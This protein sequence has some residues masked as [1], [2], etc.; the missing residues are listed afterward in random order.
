[1]ITIVFSSILFSENMGV[2]KAKV[3]K[4]IKYGF[5][6]TTFAEVDRNDA[7]TALKTWFDLLCEESGIDY[8]SEVYIYDS[9][10]LILEAIK[11][12]KIDFVIVSPME[13]LQ[14]K[15]KCSIIPVYFGLLDGKPDAVELLLVNADSKI[16][17]VN[18]LKGKTLL[19]ERYSNGRIPMI[20]LETILLKNML[21]ETGK[22]FHS[23]RQLEKVSQAV[24]PV[25]FRQA[26]ACIVRETAFETMVELNPQIG[27]KL[28]AIASSSPL[29]IG[30]ICY[31]EGFNENDLNIIT[32]S[33]LN[34]H[35]SVRGKQVLSIFKIDRLVSFI[36]STLETTKE[37][38]EEY[39]NL[40]GRSKPSK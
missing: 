16:T 27:R 28:V 10:E 6:S 31:R 1:M 2:R 19:W 30:A 13:L 37:I 36:D 39:E 33:A 20:W 17:S 26:D 35:T 3:L 9:V 15:D 22:F 12:D 4:P 38:I 34:L 18:Q 5:S 29:L 40:K 32:K 24:L 11:N 7:V 21:P 8:V 25:F 23:V 14:I